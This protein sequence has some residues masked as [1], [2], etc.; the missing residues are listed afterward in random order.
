MKEEEME[1]TPFRVIR[2]AAAVLGILGLSATLFASEFPRLSGPYL[3]QTPP[4][5]EP[6]VFAP[7]V[8]NTPLNTRDMAI[9]PDGKEIYFCVH[10]GPYV[11]SKIMVTREIDGIWSEPEVAPFSRDFNVMDLEPAISPDGR[12]FYFMSDRLNPQAGREKGNPDI[13]CMSRTGS[14]W[15]IPEPMPE[16]INTEHSEFF[17]S[18]TRDGTL[19]FTRQRQGEAA[20]MIYRA[21]KEDDGQRVVEMLGS[22]IN[23]GTTQFNAFV[24]PDERYVITCVIGREDSV[25]ST[26]YYV[27]FR[28]EDDSWRGPINLGPLI[29]T[30]GGME[31]SPY[32]SP[33]GRY[34]FFMS[35][36]APSWAEVFEQEKSY[37]AIQRNVHAVVNGHA[38]MYWMNAG[39]IGELMF[40]G[41]TR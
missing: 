15:G 3:G 24:D 40:G 4:G 23:S 6:E 31:F 29:N 26:D 10:I 7:G 36:R 9:S 1:W 2:R 18:V 30:P 22:A 17:P 19:Y 21:R 20:N 34:F 28:E 41:G 32:V 39:F 35:S 38:K 12:T 27:S 37:Q 16:P 5:D 8:V 13:W 33:D 25:G 14:T 11:M